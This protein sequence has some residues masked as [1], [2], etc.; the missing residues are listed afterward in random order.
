MRLW[1]I[2]CLS[3]GSSKTVIT[4][5]GAEKKHEESDGEETQEK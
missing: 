4:I 1:N 2:H 3:C 5:K